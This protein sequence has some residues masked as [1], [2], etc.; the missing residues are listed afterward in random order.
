MAKLCAL[1][2]Q[3][4]LHPPLRN[5]ADGELAAS[6]CGESMKARGVKTRADS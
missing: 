4:C 6:A 2:A 5:R 1:Y 3:L